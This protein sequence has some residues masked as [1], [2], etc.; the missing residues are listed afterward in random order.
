MANIYCVKDGGSYHWNDPNAWTGGVVPTGS[1]DTA[2]IQHEF[3]QIN[4]GSGYHYWEGVRDKIVVD[5]G[6][7]FASTSG[8]F[9]TWVSPS[10]FRVQITYDSKDGNSLLNCRI[11]SSY[12]TW[13]DEKSGSFDV[14][15]IRN[16]TP[17][18]TQ[19]TTIYLSGSSTWH[20]SRIFV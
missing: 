5:S 1:G 14:G 10:M 2:Y 13:T 9:F 15:F 18:F 3:T 7:N 6:T 12:S 11:S 17:V 16:D 19:P 4:S 20:I 8:S